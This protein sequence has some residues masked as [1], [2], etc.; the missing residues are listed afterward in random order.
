MKAIH[1]WPLLAVL[2]AG[3]MPADPE[4]RLYQAVASNRSQPYTIYN[5]PSIYLTTGEQQV[6][7]EKQARSIR[8]YIRADMTEKELADLWGRPND[9]KKSNYPGGIFDTFIYESAGGRYSP[10]EHYYFIFRDKKLES[11]H[12]L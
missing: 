1:F 6:R 11:W 9:I 7:L 10:A 3:C 5:Y 8:D 12:R 4:A 2:M